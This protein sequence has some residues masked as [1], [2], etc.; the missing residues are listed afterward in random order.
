MAGSS[1][2]R[3]SRKMS[4]LA[5]AAAAAGASPPL[6]LSTSNLSAVASES[7]DAVVSLSA[8]CR[9]NLTAALAEVRRVLKS[10]GRL[11][12]FEPTLGLGS[13]S[14]RRLQVLASPLHE[15]LTDGCRLDDDLAGLLEEGGWSRQ[16]MARHSLAAARSWLTAPFVLGV[17]RP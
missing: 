17:W 7:V 15:A 13:R 2:G 3:H 9:A 4:Y 10:N 11:V 14:T 6:N 5:A 16:S 1:R 8:L 12:V